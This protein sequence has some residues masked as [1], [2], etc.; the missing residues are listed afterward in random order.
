MVA[1]GA[2]VLFS[3]NGPLS[4]VTHTAG[5]AAVTVPVAGSYQISYSV[6]LTVG[7]GAAI[8][9]TVNATVD[10]STN[11]TILVGTGVISGTAILTLA[12]GDTLTLRNNSAIP[13]TTDAAPGVGVQLDI[14]FLS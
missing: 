7:V 9:I 13:I 6:S 10:A 8:A 5:T 1:G 11:V 4:G 14:I 2:D 12:A 3:N